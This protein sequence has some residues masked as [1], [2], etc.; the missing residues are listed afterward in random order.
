MPHARIK[1]PDFGVLCCYVERYFARHGRTEWPTV[2]RAAR[3]LGWTQDRVVEAVE[4]D[5]ESRMFLSAYNTAPP[6]TRGEHFVE[7]Y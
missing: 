6:Q 1:A 2:R 3:A 4:G 5:P 7:V